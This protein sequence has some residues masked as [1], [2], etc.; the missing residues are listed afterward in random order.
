PYAPSRRPAALAR[1]PSPA[2]W[3]SSQRQLPAVECLCV[4]ACRDRLDPTETHEPAERLLGEPRLRPLTHERFE[5]RAD[6]S[7]DVR[8]VERDVD[9]GTPEV[10]VELRDLVLENQLIAERLICELGQ[11]PVVL[12]PICLVAGED[13]VRCSIGTEYVEALFQLRRDVRKV[14]LP[15]RLHL[16]AAIR[17]GAEERLG[18]QPRLRS[19]VR[20][21]TEDDPSNLERRIRLEEA[22]NGPSAA[23][24]D[25]V[26]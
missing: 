20:L 13:G 21:S 12:V 18:A 5:D 1:A 11:E 26:R 19:S 4:S 8:E 22:E 7:L 2:A 10:A 24:L 15:E 16:D 9:V 3:T 25:V 14:A 17:A 6:L 23:D